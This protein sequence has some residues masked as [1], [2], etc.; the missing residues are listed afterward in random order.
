MIT[1]IHNDEK[2]HHHSLH[3]YAKGYCEHL[4]H[5]QSTLLVTLYHLQWL[6]LVNKH[7][8]TDLFLVHGLTFGN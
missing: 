8:K 2:T 5:G 7:T 6:S 3:Y 1:L 4:K